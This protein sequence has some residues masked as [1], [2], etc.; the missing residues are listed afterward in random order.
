MSAIETVT[1]GVPVYR[2]ELFI[3]ETLRSI[4]SQTHQ[5]IEVV[6]S[7]DGPQPIAVELCRPFLNDSRF[8]LV[9]QP[10]RLG[11]VANLNWLMS[12][13]TTPYW[14]FHQQDDLMDPQ[15][16]EVLVDYA[17]RTPEGAVF[18]CDIE[19]FGSLTTTFAQPSVTGSASARQL[20]LL[21]EHLTAAAFRGL[22]RLEALTLAD[23]IPANEVESFA[24][25]TV[26]MSAIARWGEL[27]RVPV[28]LYRKRYHAGNEHMRWFTW[29]IEKRIKAWTVHCAAML[30]QAMLVEATAQERRLLWLAT[31]ARL[32]SSRTAARYLPIADWTA[33]ERSSLLDAFIDYVP[34]ATDLDIP[35]L[36]ESSW[37]EVRGWSREFYWLPPEDRIADAPAPNV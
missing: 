6:I 28:T 31:V 35:A 16:L 26:W 11:W 32:A 3:E 30:E 19:A 34:T 20:A 37:T 18:Y 21:Y 1:I 12:R 17:R 22:T 14:C 9:T 27:R 7:L 36:L 29:P 15:Y 2:G 5:A 33:V 4:Q 10:Q 23:G 24:C 8:R 25:D 13:V